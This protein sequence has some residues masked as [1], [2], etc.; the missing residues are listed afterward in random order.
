MHA[1]RC[2]SQHTNRLSIHNVGNK[3]EVLPHF[4]HL[5]LTHMSEFK[6]LEETKHQSSKPLKSKAEP[7]QELQPIS[8]SVLGLCMHF[9]LLILSS[10]FRKQY[11]DCVNTSR[12]LKT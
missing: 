3:V 12:T 7:F 5:L 11:H 9:Y 2:D 10:Y 1:L 8:K 6:H 4:A